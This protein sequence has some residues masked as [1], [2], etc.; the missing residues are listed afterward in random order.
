ML[1]SDSIVFIYDS[2]ISTEELCGIEGKIRYFKES[3]FFVWY[4]LFNR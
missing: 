4:G 1:Y 2:S 3:W